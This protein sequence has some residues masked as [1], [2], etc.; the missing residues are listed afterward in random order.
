MRLLNPPSKRSFLSSFEPE[1]QRQAIPC[2]S[3]SLKLKGRQLIRI[4]ICWKISCFGMRCS[5]DGWI[6]PSATCSAQLLFVGCVSAL[7]WCHLTILDRRLQC[8]WLFLFLV[9]LRLIRDRES[10]K[11][12]SEELVSEDRFSMVPTSHRFRLFRSSLWIG[13]FFL[14]LLRLVHDHRL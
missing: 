5:G 11:L 14:V 2:V 8:W 9:P 10:Y 1:T 3:L 12:V 4:L 7:L 13:P 6:C